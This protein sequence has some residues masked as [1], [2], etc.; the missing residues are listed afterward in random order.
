MDGFRL[1]VLAGV[2]GGALVGG[3]YVAASSA[4]ADLPRPSDAAP[5]LAPPALSAPTLPPPDASILEHAHDDAELPVGIDI[6]DGAELPDHVAAVIRAEDDAN[7]ESLLD[8]ATGLRM[9]PLTIRPVAAPVIAEGSPGHR[10][11]PSRAAR[12]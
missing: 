7:A 10:P 12:G 5:A 11:P 8:E 2:I 4:R 1:F 3:L 6:S 9:G